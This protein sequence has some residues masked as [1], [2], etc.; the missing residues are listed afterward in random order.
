ME[1]LRLANEGR[2]SVQPG[3][4]ILVPVFDRRGEAPAR[5][6]AG[7]VHVVL[8]GESLWSIAKQEYG[9]GNDWQK[10][11]DANRDRLSGPEDLRAGLELIVP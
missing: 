1:L 5:P 11:L 6:S 4:T 8:E 2:E 7:R 9:R 3:E 10:L